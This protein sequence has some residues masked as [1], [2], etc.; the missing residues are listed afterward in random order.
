MIEYLICVLET[1]PRSSLTLRLRTVQGNSLE[2]LNERLLIWSITLRYTE[3]NLGTDGLVVI[4]YIVRFSLYHKCY[5]I[6]LPLLL[7]H[8]ECY[9]VKI[10]K[11]SSSVY[12]Y[13]G[14]H[15]RP[16]TTFWEIS[17]RRLN[18]SKHDLE[19]CLRNAKSI[20]FIISWKNDRCLLTPTLSCIFCLTEPTVSPWVSGI[21]KGLPKVLN[22]S[23]L[24]WA[25]GTRMSVSAISSWSLGISSSL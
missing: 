3:S 15:E 24:K 19:T 1:D 20:L 18:S 14:S 16:L 2:V 5:S 9:S 23:L 17:E 6:L 4:L 13:S 12:N 7:T 10:S 22:T 8:L 25:T 11:A 21:R